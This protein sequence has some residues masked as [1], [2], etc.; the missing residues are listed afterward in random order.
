MSND[1]EDVDLN[2][3]IGTVVRAW[4]V[5][6]ELTV[7]ELAEKAG[8]PVTKGYLSE[9]EHNKTLHPGNVHLKKL[10]DALEIPVRHL[11]NRYFPDEAAQARQSQP[12]TQS[13]FSFGAPVISERSSANRIAIL[14]EIL[15]EI[16]EMNRRSEE[17]RQVAEKLLKNEEGMR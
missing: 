9:L 13:G 3:P 4:R 14:K 6:R 5:A 10:A 12:I 16:A 17:L 11:I 2:I 15:R 7:T 8:R 1:I